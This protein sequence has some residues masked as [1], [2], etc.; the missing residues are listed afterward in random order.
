MPAHHRILNFVYDNP[1]SLIISLG[2]PFAGAVLYQQMQLNHLT[3]SQRVMH[4]RVFAQAGILTIALSTMAFREYMNKN[5][6][7]PE[8][9]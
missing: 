9:K 1:F 3:I 7:F 8:P 2:V 5:G 4:S 6:R